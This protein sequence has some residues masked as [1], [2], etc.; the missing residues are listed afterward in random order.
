[1][2]VIRGTFLGCGAEKRSGSEPG[3]GVGWW[4]ESVRLAVTLEDQGWRS[5]SDRNACEVASSRADCWKSLRTTTGVHFRDRKAT[6]RVEVLVGEGGGGRLG[7][8]V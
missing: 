2:N 3:M 8:G 1:M 6:W 5:R 7:F 4:S